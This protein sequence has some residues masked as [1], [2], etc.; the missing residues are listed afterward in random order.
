MFENNRILVVDDNESIHDDFRKIL[1]S[2]RKVEDNNYISLEKELFGN[3]GNEVLSVNFD[4][5]ID[6]CFQGEQAF[7]LVK[8]AEFEKKP[9]AIIFMDVRMPPGWDGIETIAR[10]WEKY[11]NI[12]IVICSAYSD[13]SWDK[14]ISKLGTNDR[15]LFLK[16]PFDAVEVQQMALALVK[17]WNLAEKARHYVDDLEREVARR[18]KQL[19]SMVQ[20]LIT[21]RDKLK[22]EIYTRKQTEQAL[23]SEKEN[24]AVTLKS[25]KDAVITIDTNG[26]V[27][28]VNKIAEEMIGKT[29]NEILS[30]PVTQ[31]LHIYNEKTRHRIN[32]YNESYIKQENIFSIQEEVVIITSGEQT[33]KLVAVNSSPII[34][35]NNK[36]NGIVI[37]LRD[38]SEKRKLEEELITAKKLDSVASFAGSIAKDFSNISTGISNNINIA[39][40]LT[41]DSE[42]LL[43]CLNMIEQFSLKAGKLSQQLLSFSKG[44]SPVKEKIYLQNS[45]NDFINT[46]IIDPNIDLT[47][48]I[49]DEL[50]PVKIDKEQII[51]VFTNLLL[52][53]SES[54][55]QGGKIV[56]NA[57]NI[58]IES[59]IE[60]PLSPGTYIK[61]SIKDEGCGI[62]KENLEKIFEPDFTTKPAGTALGLG[63]SSVFSIIKKHDGYIIAESEF[64]KGSTFT[65]YLPACCLVK[66]DKKRILILEKEDMIRS[67]LKKILDELGYKA[68]IAIDSHET[69]K[70]FTEAVNLKD[71]ISAVIIDLKFLNSGNQEIIEKLRAITPDIKV[72]ASS[73]YNNEQVMHRYKESGFNGVITKPFRVNEL[74]ELLKNVLN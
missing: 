4:Y 25:I 60:I 58:K 21:S 9:Y 1:L 62:E 51:Q 44:G 55:Q 67:I 46:D 23:A 64:G 30:R 63:L 10:I 5:Q 14:I 2:P 73:N 47:V 69:I 68:E 70:I 42:K 48:D 54:M 74:Q 65:F 7:E 53:A 56:I 15:L 39:R 35:K 41:N 13:Y 11:P 17:K 72:I 37:I 57:E 33:E 6:F 71:D 20:E 43:K 34:D 31:I 3:T 27:T 38:I 49:K 18:T 32:I 29:A 8:T 59:K 52:N 61:I 50:F 45:L 26:Y 16:K 66:S 28:L 22:Q 12:E 24:L 19:K 40:T 36:I